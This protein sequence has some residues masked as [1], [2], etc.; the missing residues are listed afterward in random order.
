MGSATLACVL[1]CL[2]WHTRFRWPVVILGALFTLGVGLSR[3]YLGVHYP[4]DVLAG[5]AAAI[6]W[7]LGV[8]FVAFHRGLMTGTT[9][10]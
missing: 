4:S 8:R 5:W 6:A 7:V 1:A 10:V 3:V 2:A 9:R